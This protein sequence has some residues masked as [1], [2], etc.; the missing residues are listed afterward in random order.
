MCTGALAFGSA[1]DS[2]RSWA[3]H[4][5]LLEPFLTMVADR[6]ED[7]VLQR[8]KFERKVKRRSEGSRSADVCSSLRVQAAV[9]PPSDEAEETILAATTH[10]P[11]PM[12]LLDETSNGIGWAI[13]SLHKMTNREG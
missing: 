8:C 2:M 5:G 9:L 7:K 4:Q 6:A 3:S 1:R 13:C 12:F 11:N 10:T